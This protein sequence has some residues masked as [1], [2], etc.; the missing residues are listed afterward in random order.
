MLRVKTI[1]SWIWWS[2]LLPLVHHCC[3]LCA[4][5]MDWNGSPAKQWDIHQ[6]FVCPQVVCFRLLSRGQQDKK[7]NVYNSV[8]ISPNKVHSVY[9]LLHMRASRQSPRKL[10]SAM[11]VSQYSCACYLPKTVFLAFKDVCGSS[12]TQVCVHLP[13]GEEQWRRSSA[14][15]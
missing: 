11:V 2:C 7:R 8:H 15:G 5:Q 14:R 3:L 1:K 12:F 9:T 10:W 4:I 13:W 6:L